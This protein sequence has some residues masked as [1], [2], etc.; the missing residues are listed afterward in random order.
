MMNYRGSISM[1]STLVMTCLLL[2]VCQGNNTSSQPANPLPQISSESARRDGRQFVGSWQNVKNPR[3]TL[4]ITKEGDQ[5]ILS[6]RNEKVMP[7]YDSTNNVLRIQRG[8]FGE[9]VISHRDSTD[10]LL[11]EGDEYKRTK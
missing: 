10:T 5:F 6:Q 8:I 9:L 2:L 7:L 4:T 3:D 1:R 11:G